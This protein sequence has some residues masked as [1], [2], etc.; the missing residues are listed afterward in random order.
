MTSAFADQLT[1]LQRIAAFSASVRAHE[2]G[3]WHTGEDL[4]WAA[5]RCGAE[6]HVS[7]ST[8]QPSVDGPALEQMCGCLAEKAA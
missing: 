2:L 3:D 4:A 1:V 6:L 7:I 5:C 8:L